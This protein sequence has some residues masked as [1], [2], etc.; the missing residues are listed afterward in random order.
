[1]SLEGWKDLTCACGNKH[2]QQA[3][4]LIWHESNG[5]T[6]KPDGFVCTGCGR[7]SDSAA[8]ISR[9]KQQN[10]QRKIDELEAQRERL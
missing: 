8:M 2:F 6:V 9:A 10:L 4:T 5:T 1:M 7:R 3:V